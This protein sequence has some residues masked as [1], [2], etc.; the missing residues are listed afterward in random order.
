M[1]GLRIV[2]LLLGKLLAKIGKKIRPTNVDCVRVFFAILTIIVVL[3][4]VII[5][6]TVLFK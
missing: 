3:A 2:Y 4:L 1:I 5:I 6:P